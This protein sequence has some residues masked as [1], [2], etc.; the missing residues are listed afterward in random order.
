MAGFE[1]EKPA[2]RNVRLILTYSLILQEK[3]T[4]AWSIP[5][6]R[7]RVHPKRNGVHSPIYEHL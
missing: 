3:L 1:G 5:I 7:N 2:T 6:K 4:D